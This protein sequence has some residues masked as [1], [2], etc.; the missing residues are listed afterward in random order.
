MAVDS[1]LLYFIFEYRKLFIWTSNYAEFI[2]DKYE[3]FI[4]VPNRNI[5]FHMFVILE[6]ARPN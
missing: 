5:Y 2:F 6:F 4:T 1:I 3:I